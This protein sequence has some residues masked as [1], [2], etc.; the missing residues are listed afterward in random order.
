MFLCCPSLRE[1]IGCWIRKLRLICQL[2]VITYSWS[3]YLFSVDVWGWQS[4]IAPGKVVCL[5]LLRSLLNIQNSVIGH[6]SLRTPYKDVGK[7]SI[8]NAG[9]GKGYPLQYSALENSMDCVVRGVAK[10]PTWLSD[11]HQL[12]SL[13]SLFYMHLFN[14]IHIDNCHTNYK[15]YKSIIHLPISGQGQVEREELYSK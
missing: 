8:C 2:S 10:S 4:W 13:H 6:I 9:E 12:M 15:K 14:S 7:E 3:G 11:F 5:F 1:R